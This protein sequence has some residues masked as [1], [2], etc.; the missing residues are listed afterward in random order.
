M[1]LAG[2]AD[3]ALEIVGN[4]YLALGMPR[5]AQWALARSIRE[6]LPFAA[7]AAAGAGIG[8]A[9]VVQRAA[10]PPSREDA[11]RA[12]FYALVAALGLSLASW[13]WFPPAL[14]VL[15]S[16]GF[17]VGVLIAAWAAGLP[18]QRSA[19]VLPPLL[20][21][22]L[23]GLLSG[24]VEGR[25]LWFD[26]APTSIGV[27]TLGGAAVASAAWA[28]LSMRGPRAVVAGFAV[29]AALSTGL[30][31]M[32]PSA[33]ATGPN[34]LILGLDTTRT[35]HVEVERPG[36]RDLTPNLRALAKRGT[37]YTDAVTQAPWTMPGFMSALTGQYPHQHGAASLDATVPRRVV[38]LHERLL[39]AGY[40]TGLATTNAYTSPKVHFDQGIEA[41]EM[42]TIGWHFRRSADVLSD[43]AADFVLGGDGPAYV[44]IGYIDPHTPF[45]DH[46]ESHFADGYDGWVKRVGE[47]PGHL[48]GPADIQYLNDLY[49]EEIVYTDAA[50]GRMLARF[51]AAGVLGDTLIVAVG[52]HGEEI[53]ERG[54][55]GHTITLHQ[56][57]LGVPLIVV[58]P[59][60]TTGRVVRTPVETRRVA[61]TVLGLL[62][63]PYD[64]DAAPLPDHDEPGAVAFSEVNLL[65]VPPS[66][67]HPMAGVALTSEEFRW[68]QTTNPDG[69]VLYR[70][71][72]PET[73]SVLADHPEA[74]AS[75]R[76]RA[77]VDIE[78][79][80]SFS[81]STSRAVSDSDLEAL[82]VLGYV[83]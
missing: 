47:P 55:L 22:V 18:V 27:A 19:W 46:V 82:R 83:Q 4:Q 32:G 45:L 43:W 51:E 24:F 33:T 78:A 62:G 69:E 54:Y 13:L 65:H 66:Y 42:S 76:A 8:V 79:S 7:L 60:G 3:G 63:L 48:L 6:A 21:L 49:D 58:P 81:S 50:I 15:L 44:F 56:E 30:G 25:S 74:A 72:E 5:N 35:D 10:A 80:T 75:L 67:S 16:A 61:P 28:V 77:P 52:D 9:L 38:T 57:V 12:G 36:A 1:I 59:G 53:Y 11:I 26:E 64:G 23:G 31:A 17:V 20:T 2:L 39:E 37:A 68:I 40:R 73:E 41:V 71:G 29:L 14:G 70:R 34:V